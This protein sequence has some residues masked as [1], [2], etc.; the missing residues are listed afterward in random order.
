MA[1]KKRHVVLALLSVLG[2]ILFLD[3]VCI[4]L[5]L[6]QI[7]KE[8][9]IDPA[10][11]GWLTVAFNVAYGAFE[12]P[13]GH[14]GDRYGSRSALARITV[15]WSIFTAATGVAMGYVSLLVVRFFFG[16]GEAGAWPNVTNVISKWFPAR[17][18]GRA[19]SI[20]GAAT[21]LGGGLAPLLVIPIQSAWGW[22]ASFVLFAM[23]GIVWSCVWY[24]WFRDS[25]ADMNVPAEELAELGDVR[26]VPPLAEHHLPWKHALR[27]PTLWGLFAFGSTNVF[28]Y[29]FIGFWLPTWLKEARQFTDP[30]LKWTAA[31][32]ISALAGNLAGGQ[33][34]DLFVKRFGRRIGRS[35]VGGGGMVVVAVGLVAVAQ[36]TDKIN[37]LVAFSVCG[38]CWG[39]L[40]VNAFA[41]VMDIGGRHVGTVAGALNT[42][43][44][45]GGIVS[46]VVVGTVAQA[47]NWDVPILVMAGTSLVGAASWFV[48]NANA[49]LVDAP[50]VGDPRD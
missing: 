12:I 2:A 7:R 29:S 22:R 34:S 10:L 3:R 31:V 25:L 28:C 49:P 8:L 30:E 37:V 40:Q 33:L 27:S 26:D 18:R 15:F 45:L 44:Q 4:S 20:F 16:A 21:A 43:A 23:F 41:T 1:V 48:I 5:A 14:L 11:A 42:S 50:A 13:A 6:P 17:S 47:T 46:G 24:L 19:M 38:F 36:I 32:W 39:A 35:L 9:D